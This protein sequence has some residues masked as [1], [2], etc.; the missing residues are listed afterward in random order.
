MQ[1]GGIMLVGSLE[2]ENTN[3]SLHTKLPYDDGRELVMSQE[4]G[5]EIIYDGRSQIICHTTTA[6]R[7][8]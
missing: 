4:Y 5:N 8:Y 1:M 6:T 7:S 3:S 2:E